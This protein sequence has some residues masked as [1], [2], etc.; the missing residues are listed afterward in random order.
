MTTVSRCIPGQPG[1]PG[2]ARHLRRGAA[3]L[4][5]LLSAGAA[6]A[7]GSQSLEV[8][9]TVLS[10][11]ACRFTNGG[12]SQLAFGNIDPSAGTTVSLVVATTFRCTGSDAVATY[13]ISSDDGLYAA[14]PGQP[15]MRHATDPTRYLPYALNIPQS[16]S[17]P[18]NTTQTLSIEGTLT[19]ADYADAVAGAYADTVVLTIEP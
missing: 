5:L 11:N 16:A 14:G 18:K 2:Q 3:A 4:G 13:S 10:K 17:V 8:S 1:Q 6:L 9:A 15:R 7:A 12:P 19:P